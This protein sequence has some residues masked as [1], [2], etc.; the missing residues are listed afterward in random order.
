MSKVIL[1]K[2]L[3]A[4][5]K[6]TWAK[7]YQKAHPDAVRTNKDELRAMLHNSVWSKGK[8]W[9]VVNVRDFIINQAMTDGHDVI[10]DDTNLHL[11]HENHIREMMMDFNNK[12]NKKIEFVIQDFTNVPLDV[13]LTRD[14]VRPNA[15]GEKVIRKMYDQFLKPEV[16]LV[17][18]NPALPFAIISDLDGTLADLDGRDP[19]NAST[20]ETDLVKEPVAE[21]L[22]MFK[23]KGDTI[24]L[25]SGRDGVH[26][27]PTEAWLKAKNIPYDHLFMRAEGDSRNDAIIKKEIYDANIKDKWNVR[28][29]LDDRLKV[30]RLWHSLGLLLLRV[31]DPDADF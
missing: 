3:P 5:G 17:E 19:Y 7:D 13:C 14:K 27:P 12:N 10:V 24:I 2:G 21:I 18:S 16:K 23:A 6:S 26:R 31:G 4:S 1:T 29:V 30:A 20:C 15:V 25:V 9:T 28:C 8:E 11:K 22:R